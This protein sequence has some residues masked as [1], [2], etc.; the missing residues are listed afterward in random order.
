MV[1]LSSSKSIA[2]VLIVSAL[3]GNFLEIQIIGLCLD[4]LNQKLCE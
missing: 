1:F 2:S 3:P 4:L